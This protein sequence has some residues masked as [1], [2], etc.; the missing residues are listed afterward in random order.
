MIFFP[1]KKKRGETLHFSSSPL[2]SNSSQTHPPRRRRP[3]APGV[4]VEEPQR[5]HVRDVEPV[6]EHD[7][8]EPFFL[9]VAGDLV[10][11]ARVVLL[12]GVDDQEGAWSFVKEREARERER[13]R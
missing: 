10:D 1:P 3:P 11:L 2:Q 5:G 7:E 8:A 4:V 12:L 9:N 13:K 6:C